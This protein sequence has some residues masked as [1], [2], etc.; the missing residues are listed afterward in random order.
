[1]MTQV[2]LKSSQ[3]SRV[4]TF[5]FVCVKYSWGSSDVVIKALKEG[6][7]SGLRLVKRKFD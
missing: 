4:N 6:V 5:G 3:A 1:M 2:Y 7:F